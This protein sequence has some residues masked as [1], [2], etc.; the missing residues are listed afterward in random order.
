M[1]ATMKKTLLAS[2]VALALGAAAGAEASLV[3]NLLGPNDWSTNS[4]NFTVLSPN[5]GITGG[6]NDVDMMW[7]GNGYSSDT[8]YTGPGGAANVTMSS[9]TP[10][11]G[12]LWTMHDIQVFVPGSYSFDTTV[13]GGS[14]EVGTINVTVGAGQIGMHMLWDWNGNLN[15]DVFVV[16]NL[17]SVFGAG[18]G[19]STDVQCSANYTGT[20]KKNCLFDGPGYGSA[21]QPSGTQTWMLASSDPDGD[22]IMGVPMAAG[23]PT[24]GYTWNLNANLSPTPDPIPVPAAVWLFGSGLLGLVGVA[25]RRKGV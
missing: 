13:G 14:S 16:A 2:S 4:A 22:G 20:I 3:T 17:S 23:G 21:G 1:N 24:A 8:D 10:F 18:V 7:D 19:S 6:T 9:T 11:F 12:H 5:G 15:V 25:R